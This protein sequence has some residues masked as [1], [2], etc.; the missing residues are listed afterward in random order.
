MILK[1][2]DDLKKFLNVERGDLSDSK[3]L[4]AQTQND[5]RFV[6]LQQSVL[7]GKFLQDYQNTVNDIY[8]IV[9]ELKALGHIEP[10]VATDNQTDRQKLKEKKDEEATTPTGRKEELLKQLSEKRK[11]RDDLVMVTYLLIILE[12]LY[13]L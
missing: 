5:L 12:L 7:A 6:D 8:D 3:F 13:S 1:T 10:S 4:D 9:N 11:F 2:I